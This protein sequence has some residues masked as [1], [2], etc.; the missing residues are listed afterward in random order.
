M[1]QTTK[2]DRLI[3]FSASPGPAQPVAVLAPKSDLGAEARS[4]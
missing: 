1:F 4:L 2:P 3:F